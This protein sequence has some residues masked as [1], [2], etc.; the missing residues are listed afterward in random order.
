[1]IAAPGI[2]A[3]AGRL[4]Q[5]LV[6]VAVLVLGTAAAAFYFA[7]RAP[8]QSNAA[9]SVLIATAF[10][11]QA[12]SA[13]DAAAAK[14]LAQDVKALRSAA[15]RDPNGALARDERFARVVSNAEA[16]VGAASSLAAAE[17]AARQARE[18]VASML[19]EVAGL[20]G[21]LS[22]PALDAG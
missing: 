10:D 16:V 9:A 7:N 13:G 12:A 21:T 22:G 1:M 17:E 8:A 3:S 2:L 15:E 14:R 11:A 20:A 18:L 19:A 5:L 6:A 4:N